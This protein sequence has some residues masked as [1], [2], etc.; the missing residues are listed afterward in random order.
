MNS[1]KIKKV[2]RETHN[3]STFVVDPK[4]VDLDW[5]PK[6]GQYITVE[7][8]VAG[9]TLRRSYSLS[10][11]P[12]EHDLAFTIKRV[13][14]GRV[15]NYMLDNISE[16][17]T[18]KVNKPEG[19][20][21]L[22]PNADARKDY[23][24]FAAGSGIT[25]IISMIRS[26]LEQEPMSSAYLLYGNRT[27]EDIIFKEKLDKLQTEYRD[28]IYVNYTLSKPKKEK[29][30][31]IAGMFS[32]GTISWRGLKGRIDSEMIKKFLQD[33][34]SK[35]GKNEFFICG[36]GNFISYTEQILQ[37]EGYDSNLIKKEF[38]T[39]PDAP[40]SG[41]APAGAKYDGEATVKVTLNGETFEV[42]HSNDK[43]ILETIMENGKNPPYSCTAGAC[44]SCVAKK[45]SGEVSMDSCFALEDD[46]IEEGFILTCQARAE[47]KVVEIIYEE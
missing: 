45:V 26:V 6:A 18:L 41:A 30:A 38:F 8:E 2:I 27:E 11:S 20:F 47:S 7:V 17:S 39:T 29:K 25:P 37:V 3:V 16:G 42:S 34:P 43:T 31:G 15:S 23:Y 12:V 21:Q 1:L 14:G 19:K 32:K 44:S 24:F 36:P 22:I 46:E 40:S 5:K 4:A 35:S 9:E 33:F 28:Q 13:E 10:S